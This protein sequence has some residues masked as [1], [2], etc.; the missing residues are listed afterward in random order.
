VLAVVISGCRGASAIGSQPIPLAERA[1]WQTV[2]AD[3]TV[4]MAMD[5]AHVRRAPGEEWFVTFIT[6]HAALIGPDTLRFDRGR[7]ALLV[8][9]DP[10][11]FKSISEELALGDVRPVFN[12]RWELTG[13]DAVPWNV[14]QAGRLTIGFFVRPAMV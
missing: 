3:A 5:T 11:S 2:L 9:C 12:Q 7:I 10:G 1:P 14:P 13:P 4:R 6:T 8:R